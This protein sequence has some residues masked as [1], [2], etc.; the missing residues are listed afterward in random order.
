MRSILIIA[1]REVA[2]LFVSPVAYF[3]LFLFMI[4]MGIIFTVRVFVPGRFVE[5][6]ELI[7]WSRFSLFFVVPL[8]TMSLLSEEYSTGRIEI[9]RT[10]PISEMQL[11]L[12][13]FFGAMTY[14]LFLIFCSLVYLVL[15]MF[16]GKPDYGQ[17]FAA[18]IG[19][20]FMGFM[21][22]S[23]GL[24]YSACTR[25]QIVA[26]LASI[27][28]LGI[29]V[30]LSYLS[31]QVPVTFLK[32]PLRAITEYLAVGTHIGD[33]ARG[34]IQLTNVVYFSGFSLLFLFWTYVVLE[35]RKWR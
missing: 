24:F 29:L 19:M 5:I 20:V 2:S 3:V 27:I 28:T 12:G 7:D 33:F 35:S 34:S 25:E 17:V 18:Y 9:I 10:S 21:F 8:L 4:F 31:P 14:Y 15:M 22:V 6:R 30:A 32:I 16:F 13:K 11:I 23:V 26:A 1:R